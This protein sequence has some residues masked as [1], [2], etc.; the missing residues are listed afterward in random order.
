MVRSEHYKEVEHVKT[1]HIIICEYYICEN[2]RS[3]TKFITIFL[4]QAGDIMG[5]ITPMMQQY[6][7]IKEQY[8][9]CIVFFRLGD[10]YEMF[11]D[12]AITASRELEITLTGRDCGLEERAPMCGIPFH[13]A[14]SYINR[15]INKGYKV[16]ICEQIEDPSL[17]KGIVKRDVI[18]VVTPGT[19]V[20][21]SALEEDKNNYIV[22]ITIVENI[23]GLA[24]CDVSTGEFSTTEIEDGSISSLLDELAKYNPSEIIISKTL[25][26]SEIVSLIN[27]KF[28]SFVNILDPW[29]FE[30]DYCNKK[31][32]DHFNII[33]LESL[34]L[35]RQ[36]I[37]TACGSLFEYLYSTQKVNLGHI[38]SINIYSLT[39]YMVL[40]SSTRRN[41]ELTETMR[42]KSRKGSLLGVLDKTLTSMGSRLIRK[43][44]EQPLIDIKNIRDR[45]D[46]VKEIKDNILLRKELRECLNK[47][48]DIE[49]LS[50]RIVYGN[51]NGRELIALKNSISVLPT[52]KKILIQCDSSLLSKTYER[53]D[54]LEDIYNIIDESI[55]EEP[56]VTIKEGGVIKPGFNNDLDRLRNISTESKSWIAEIESQEREKTG[57]KNLKIGYNKVFGYY[58][59]ITKS[60]YSL[61]PDYYIR[62]QTIANGERY[63]IPKLKEIEE[64]LVNAESK[65]IDLEYNLFTTVRLKIS[66]HIKR[67]QRVSRIIAVIDVL[68][69][70][71]EVAENNGYIMPEVN[72]ID[73]IEI[74]DGRHPVVEKMISN[75]LFVPNDTYLDQVDNRL[76]IITGPNMAGKSTYMRQVALIVLMAQ[77]GSFVPAS[78]ANIG[79]VDR[80]F[81]RVG[82]SDDLASGQST[83][84]VEMTEVANILNNSTNKSLIILDEIGRG[85]STFDGLSI[86][87]SVV[88]YISNPKIIGA[89]TLFATHY[90]ELTELEDKIHGV[91]NYCVAVKEKGDDIIFL[92][93]IIR[94]GADGSYGIQVAKL[95]GLPNDVI[96]KAKEILMKLEEADINKKPENK[97]KKLLYEGQLDIFNVGNKTNQVFE[98]IK[99]LDVTTL[100][101]IEAL[102]VL[103][104]F[105][106][107]AKEL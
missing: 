7:E 18:R 100:T 85:T 88:E 68:C 90:H 35:T 10:F 59:E 103:Y 16:A 21:N 76:M 36:A 102:N 22:S 73:T 79:V 94:G 15:L 101:P 37:V 53:L 13:S 26:N 104:R 51:I 69:S 98:E 57:I 6:L 96:E 95:A 28:T 30:Y 50:S 58:I 66:N 54:T 97:S 17:A 70:L 86:A 99:N 3:K 80:I 82:A 107:K 12:D 42:E 60:N 19:Q 41:L 33:T 49:R 72:N 11:F 38:N 43:W 1:E 71:A 8:N 20:D 29:I 65:I 105:T 74:N 2:C 44:I 84:M 5:N 106:L 81:T 23:F 9:D 75:S 89:K 55:T 67:I 4:K 32:S 61:V 63:I 87:W 27:S 25:E 31:V 14:S 56:P 52:I 91:K 39:N 40:D 83:F 92:R 46:A 78:K 62:K 34:G 45:L 64:T 47:I 77:I 24:A 48:Y 93:K